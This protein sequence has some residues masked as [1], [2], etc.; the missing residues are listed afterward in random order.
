MRTQLKRI[1]NVLDTYLFGTD[2]ESGEFVPKHIQF[3]YYGFIAVGTLVCAAVLI[4][5]LT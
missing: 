2:H 1:T 3:M 5:N 4:A